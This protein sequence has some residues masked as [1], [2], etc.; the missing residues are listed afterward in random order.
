MTKKVWIHNAHLLSS[1]RELEATT[2]LV[3]E[4]KICAIGTEA[5]SEDCER[6]DLGGQ[7]ISPGF[8]DIQLNG[9]YEHY[10]SSTPTVDVLR[11][12]TQACLE[13]ATPYYYAT[14]ITSPTEAIFSAIEA[15]RETMLSD[16]HLLGLHLEGPFLNPERRGAHQAH[17]IQ[18]PTD[19][20]VDRIIATGRGVVKMMTIA[21]EVCTTSQIARLIESGIQVS[22]GHSSA[23]YEEAQTAFEQGVDIVTHLYNAM[24]P[25]THRAPGLVGAALET[26]HVYTPIILDGRHCHPA[27]A[28]LAYK[29][30]G[31][32]LILLTDAAV[33]GRRLQRISWDGLGADLTPDGFY[34]NADGNLAGAA[35]SMPE[36][37]HNAQLY[38]GISIAEA[39]DMASGR[40][41]SAI[42]R[43]NDLGY[44]KPGYRACF[45]IFNEDLSRFSSL[46]L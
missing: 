16:R 6:I 23:S 22:I 45:S 40:V 8:I 24:S 43:S 38:L 26:P 1:G 19:D 4:G 3:E 11:E 42:G 36:A 7:Y 41:A 15:V 12:M 9:G 21:P 33:L 30:K 39:A 25:L 18:K 20:I 37:V 13:H 32:R 34:I 17:L 5:P 35:I 27:A 14:L 28:R 2:L 10:F 29:S 44:L 46:V 31:D